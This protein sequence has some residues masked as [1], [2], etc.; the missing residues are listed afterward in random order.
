MFGINL[1]FY[2]IYKMP[3]SD[4]YRKQLVRLY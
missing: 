4:I 1:Q 2:D 3:L